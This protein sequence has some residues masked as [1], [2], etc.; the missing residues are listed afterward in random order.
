MGTGFYYCK[1][2]GKCISSENVCNKIDDCGDNEDEKACFTNCTSEQKYICK[3]KKECIPTSL[4]CDGKND[5]GDNQDELNCRDAICS[6]NNDNDDDGYPL[7]C[8]SSTKCVKKAW[9]CDGD[10]DC[11]Y[12]DDEESCFFDENEFRGISEFFQGIFGG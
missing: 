9:I 10:R 5:C 11:P 8:K 1:V 7:R 3:R 2:T 12:S 4:V 6:S